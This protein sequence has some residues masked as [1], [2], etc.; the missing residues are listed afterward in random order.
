MWQ[1]FS[2]IEM[3]KCYPRL[4]V[5]TLRGIKKMKDV[6]NDILTRGIEAAVR[7]YRYAGHVITAAMAIIITT[8]VSGRF[9][10]NRPLKGGPEL[11]EELMVGV[12]F[13]LF[14]DVTWSQH[15]IKVDVFVDWLARVAPRAQKAMNI[16]FDIATLI[17]LF[18]MGWQG[19][20]GGFEAFQ[21]GEVTE[22]LRIPHYPFWMI[23]A[24]GFSLA[25]ISFLVRFIHDL[26][27][28]LRGGVRHG[29]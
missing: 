21:S 26:V 4:N 20:V 22:A 25:F 23:M 19:F 13:F 5:L 29:S 27:F 7:Y 1:S 15:H 9:L 28:Q 18:L 17:L 10:F 24:G 3:H 2:Y 8:D 6:V 16:V 14:A 12:V 11:V